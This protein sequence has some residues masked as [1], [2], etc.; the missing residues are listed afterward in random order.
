MKASAVEPV[1]IVSATTGYITLTTSLTGHKE[2][3]FEPCVSNSQ[4]RIISP[5][6]VNLYKVEGEKKSLFSVQYINVEQESIEVD[7]GKPIGGLQPC[8][9]YIYI[10]SRFTS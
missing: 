6:V 5:G 3:L 1:K 8:K 2:A 7:D 9:K 4:A 10:Y